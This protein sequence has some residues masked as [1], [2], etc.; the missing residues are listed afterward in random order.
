MKE[1]TGRRRVE[2]W[3]SKV[4]E[5]KGSAGRDQK[6]KLYTGRSRRP[7][8]FLSVAEQESATAQREATASE[9][10]ERE[11][12][13]ERED[14]DDQSM[15]RESREKRR[16]TLYLGPWDGASPPLRHMRAKAKPSAALFCEAQCVG[17]RVLQTESHGSQ[18]LSALLSSLKSNRLFYE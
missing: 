11:R 10:K 17:L 2:L 4:Q 14:K 5:R 8:S 15:K 9:E 13:R 12:K 3:R 18:C 16:P 1:E 7:V 6:R